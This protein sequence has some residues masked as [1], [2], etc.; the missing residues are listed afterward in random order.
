MVVFEDQHRRKNPTHRIG[1]SPSRCFA[2][3]FSPTQHCI[4][5]QHP[6]DRAVLVLTEDV[7]LGDLADFI[8]MTAADMTRGDFRWLIR[9]AAK[10]D[11]ACERCGQDLTAS[12]YISAETLDFISPPKP[13]PPRR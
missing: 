10:A 7:G 8:A 6:N 13:G 4:F 3:D 12:P 9:L 11:E 2:A 5:V 1:L